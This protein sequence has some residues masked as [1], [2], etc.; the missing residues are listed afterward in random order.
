MEQLQ[1]IEKMSVVSQVISSLWN[2][3]TKKTTIPSS[4]SDLCDIVSHNANYTIVVT[5][6]DDWAFAKWTYYNTR[7]YYD[8]ETLR[9]DD[10]LYFDPDWKK[11]FPVEFQLANRILQNER[12][13][14]LLCRDVK[15]VFFVCCGFD[16]GYLLTEYRNSGYVRIVF[17]DEWHD[18]RVPC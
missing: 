13:R 6:P 2:F 1:F 7:V 8:F 17:M 5:S 11:R 16:I 3:A 15:A 10:S 18:R 9:D 14:E 4:T 12:A